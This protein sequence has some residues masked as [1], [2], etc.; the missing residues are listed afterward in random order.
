MSQYNSMSQMPSQGN[1][2][3]A[4]AGNAREGYQ[5]GAGSNVVSAPAS[6]AR[7]MAMDRMQQRQDQPACTF[8]APPPARVYCTAAAFTNFSGLRYQRMSDAYGSSV[9]ASGYY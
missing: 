5:R 4:Q 7:G 3:W 2:S 1:A 6:M 9:P 8:P